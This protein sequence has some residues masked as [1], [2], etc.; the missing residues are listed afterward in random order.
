M[1]TTIRTSV[2]ETNSSSSHTFIHISKETFEAW[3]KGEVYLVDGGMDKGKVFTGGFYNST[4]NEQ[5]FTVKKKL[6]ELKKEGWYGTVLKYKDLLEY[7]SELG[8]ELV[9]KCE[10]NR[11]HTFDDSCREKMSDTEWENTP[12]HE[13]VMQEPYMDVIDNGKTVTI[14]L[15]GRYE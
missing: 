5:N 9:W 15:W 10:A 3:K 8:F 14:H 7:R 4:Y 1:K 6:K 11:E 2:F 13:C 12:D